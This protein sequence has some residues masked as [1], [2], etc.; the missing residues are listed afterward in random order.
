MNQIRAEQTV[1][2]EAHWPRGTETLSGRQ[3]LCLPRQ[4][5]YVYDW[6][7][8]A[9]AMLAITA[10]WLSSKAHYLVFCFRLPNVSPLLP[11]TQAK[12]NIS[13]LQLILI[14]DHL[15]C[16]SWINLYNTLNIFF[17]HPVFNTADY[18][19]NTSFYNNGLVYFI[20]VKNALISH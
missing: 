10:D 20:K 4:V 9:G 6:A 16:M 15:A 12:E 7:K 11:F 14:S 3:S 17:T 18:V 1:Q 2:G 13:T 19:N 8:G 5:V